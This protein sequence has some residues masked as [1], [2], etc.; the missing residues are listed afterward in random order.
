YITDLGM[1][2]SETSVL[3]I[4]PERIIRSLKTGMPTVF[5]AKETD[6]AINGCIFEI[7]EKSGLTEKIYSV[8]LRE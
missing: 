2:G 6:I 4:E 3:G 7:N 1:C 5:K 8:I